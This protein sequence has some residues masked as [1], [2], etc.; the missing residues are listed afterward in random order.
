MGMERWAVLPGDKIGT[1]ER[2][3]LEYHDHPD[4][5][6]QPFIRTSE[7]M[8]ETELRS[9]L[10]R[11]DVSDGEADAAIAQARVEREHDSD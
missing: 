11:L 1:E 8:T 4:P 6:T 9:E 5:R 3:I 2:F 10:R 7:L